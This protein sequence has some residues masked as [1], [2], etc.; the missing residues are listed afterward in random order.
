MIEKVTE[1][2]RKE[3]IRKFI[4][5][6][7]VVAL[8]MADI[9]LIGT[10]IA[11]YA[12]N[13]EILGTATNN[14]NVL[15]DGYFK[16]AQ[17]NTTTISEQS[18]NN[19]SIHL[20]MRI[21]I[22]N[23]GYFNGNITIENSNF[24]LKPDILSNKINKIEGNT[25]TLN[26][27][28][29]GEIVEIEV[30]VEPI[31]NEVVS[32]NL[33]D[34]K[35][36]VHLTGIYKDSSETDINIDA[37]REVELI[38]TSPYE[39][40]KG[41]NLNSQI[42]TNKIYNIDGQ[43]KRMVQLLIESNL[44]D[45]AY[46]VK[47]TSIEAEIPGETESVYVISRG[48]F[49]TNGKDE[50][51]FTQENWSYNQKARKI[52]IQVENKE[53]N[54]QI[55]WKKNAK[56][57]YIVT[58][59]MPANTQVT[60]IEIKTNL[61]VTLYDKNKTTKQ[62]ESTSKI[63]EE[64]DGI[65]TTN[66][67]LAEN[68]IYKG[69]LYSKE[70]RDY[71]TATKIYVNSNDVQKN[72]DIALKK[73]TYKTET[74]ELAANIQFKTTTIN[75]SEVQR[76]LGENGTLKI[77]NE[78]GEVATINKDSQTDENGNVVVT[79]PENTKEI[80]ITTSNITS[81]GTITLNNVK[82]IKND[83]YDR[84][85][86]ANI[87][88][89]QDQ[90]SIITLNETETKAELN[91][92]NTN[93]STL[94]K[95]EN[96]SITATLKTDNEKYNLYKNPVV[97]ILLPQ[98]IENVE[99]T[100]IKTVYADMFQIAEALLITH[101]NGQK[102]IRVS[103]IGEQTNYTNN[104]NQATIVANINVTFGV[105]TPSQAS[106][107]ALNYT[108]ENGTTTNTEVANIN[109][110]SKAGLM[111]Y[112]NLNN[113]NN[114]GENIYTIDDNVPEGTLDMQ[115]TPRQ[116]TVNMAVVNNYDNNLQN[117]ELLGRIPTK[118]VNNSTIDTSLASAVTT[119][120]EGAQVLY[121]QNP[122]AVATD[123]DWTEDTTNAKS[124]KIVVENMEKAQIIQIQYMFTLPENIT[125]G[126]VIYNKLDANYTY[127]GNVMSQS[128]TIGARTANLETN[129]VESVA[130]LNNV[131]KS[132][133]ANGLNVDIATTSNGSELQEGTSVYEGQ[134]IRYTMQITN[135]TGSDLSNVN[136]QAVQENGNIYD[137]LE[138]EVYDPE[139]IMNGGSLEDVKK[140]YHRY[141]ELD[142]NTKSFDVIESLPNGESISLSY[143]VIVS[144]IEEGQTYGNI[145]IN[146]DNL[147]QAQLK[148]IENPIEQSELK[149]RLQN[150]SYI[151]QNIYVTTPSQLMLDVENTS[152]KT[153]T[154]VKGS[155]QLPED[156][157]ISDISKLQ[158]KSNTI[159]EN[160]VENIENSNLVNAQYDEQTN[161]VTFELSSLEATQI[162][163]LTLNFS[164]TDFEEEE[165]NFTFTYE[166]ETDRKYTSNPTTM[167]IIGIQKDV[168]LEQTATVDE[169]TEL[170]D[171]DEFEMTININNNEEQELYM[172]LDDKLPVGIHVQSA[173]MIYQDQTENIPVKP[174][175]ENEDL[176]EGE[177]SYKNIIYTSD[178][179]DFLQVE[180]DVA[181]KSNIKIVLKVKIN[182]LKIEE[183]IIK[184]QIVLEYGEKD[185]NSSTYAFEWSNVIENTK[186]FKVKLFSEESQEDWVIVTQEG[187]PED[188][189]N[190][191]NGQ[192]INYKIYIQST[193]IFDI[194]VS[195]YN[196]LSSG[197]KVNKATLNGQTIDPN[198][199]AAEGF[200]IPA[201]ETV[202]LEVSGVVDTQSAESN[203]IE[204]Q[205]VVIADSKE[206]ASNVITYNIKNA[207]NPDDPEFPDDPDNPDNP[208]NPDDPN[209]PSDPGFP[210]DPADTQKYAITGVAWLDSNKNGQR[211][212]GED[213]LEGITVTAIDVNTGTYVQ[214]TNVTTSANGSYTINVPQ[215]NYILAF[216]YN[217]DIY[218]LT[219]YQK[220]GVDV[221]A[222]SDVIVQDIQ[223]N[224]ATS[225]VATT[226]TINISTADV[227]NI[228]I[229]LIQNSTFD[230]QLDKTVKQIVVQNREGTK[231]YDYN[232]E[233]LAK[234]EIR[235]K[236]LNNSAVII[237][238]KIKI[239]NTGEI[240]GYV[241][242]IIDNMPN[243][244]EFNSELNTDWSISN[245]TLQNTSLANTKIGAGETKELELTLTKTMTETNTGMVS[246][247]AEI[248]DATNDLG[249]ADIDSTPGNST[250][251]ED[252]YSTA[253]VIISVST[254]TLVAYIGII[255]AVLVLI[256][257]G[258]F[259]VN[260]IV[261]KRDKEI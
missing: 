10:G 158:W 101:D 169:N 12:A 257:L 91:V 23:D 94:S 2:K 200:D 205:V 141:S 256:G 130:Q 185:T 123:T 157:Y 173:V 20:F 31:N 235:S 151:E 218:S 98:N 117:V 86:I 54:G 68:N 126:Q 212:S 154:N 125:Y 214:D 146:A 93:W 43:N 16:D 28:N 120:I 109:I 170:R 35:S 136:I 199:I 143:E 187:S 237:K 25:I 259:G 50:T 179:Q 165:Q 1:A 247:S 45:N 213:L 67:E 38:L 58:Y 255:L 248:G 82:T 72:I 88:Q 216:A 240:G 134:H 260:K 219:D 60:N 152:D 106:E 164:V 19:N 78:I 105:L 241:N 132:S 217:T 236:Y 111:I 40:G 39:E 102:A 62:A 135:N 211:D 87:K 4:A 71:N 238:Y 37:T 190:V 231:T 13:E 258:A 47:E 55:S 110:E 137:L 188:Q 208:D 133:L 69:K 144:Q 76:A 129:E 36:N 172:E 183:K 34:M 210:D 242:N 191:E 201:K 75:K 24:K 207:V 64:I 99:V 112:N 79:Y 46:P 175:E 198:N 113:F 186:E 85:T 222:N 61:K 161:I 89:I 246:N 115:N 194:K 149:L 177:D 209:N 119:N 250:Q 220:T 128:S 53:E 42:L 30:L 153:L 168:T 83:G 221:S 195:I 92:S 184:N 56:D 182:T 65:I 223:I 171:G 17:G 202:I 73:A 203:K 206:I 204:N 156:T 181:G 26:K 52:N 229:G 224:G 178:N 215:G 29:N 84:Q 122:E 139:D 11:T 100:N 3:I 32:S 8:T 163:R 142:T 145:T 261:L 193:R 15:F 232:D 49:A 114:A 160:F 131:V 95:N 97:E 176:D 96:I 245:N 108:N 44:Q 253:D 167:R 48:T 27:I 81:T 155:I 116:A 74:E 197:I 77:Y 148:T 254:G 234:V 14:R 233:K 180:K 244:L 140:I 7:L 66:E 63:A 41:A 127:V 192:E 51:A 57:S 18:I 6:L 5:F 174:I 147:E 138:I 70:D 159:G 227:S 121:S 189:S 166:M 118:N 226:D 150:S 243:T 107:I 230:L 33:I 104:I 90:N 21:A 80:A 9:A 252:D 249:L 162:T 225:R 228:D 22:R 196:Y 251:S 239:T 59:I 103:L 124:F